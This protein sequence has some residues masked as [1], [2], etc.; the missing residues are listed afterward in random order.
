MSPSTQT[1][2]LFLPLFF[3]LSF[4]PRPPLLQEQT[5]TLLMRGGLVGTY[6]EMWPGSSSPGGHDWP[7]NGGLFF[8]FFFFFFYFFFN[9]V[10]ESCFCRDLTALMI[11]PSSMYT[12]VQP[13][14]HPGNT[15]S[16]SSHAN[17]VCHGAPAYW[18]LWCQHRHLWQDTL[19]GSKPL[20]LP[21]S[22]SSSFFQVT[23]CWRDEAIA[24]INITFF[25]LKKMPQCLKI[26]VIYLTKYKDL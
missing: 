10:S 3:S 1:C 22:S 7:T 18:R 9:A 5:H 13:T 19:F 23:V 6:E 25:I 24:G 15:H 2:L 8:F 17:Q 16:F 11:T 14:R 20:L 4:S 21:F 12:S 26:T